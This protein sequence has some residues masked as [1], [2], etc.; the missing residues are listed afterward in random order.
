M[1]VIAA[2]RDT[3][4]SIALTEQLKAHGD[5]IKKDFKPIFEPIPHVNNLPRD[6]L[7]HIKLKEAECTIINRTYTCPQKYKEAFQVLIQ[8][9]QD[10]GH[11]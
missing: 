4:E 10:A 8:Q 11:I 1:D 5:K 2:I 7:A 6:Y 3:I 9:H